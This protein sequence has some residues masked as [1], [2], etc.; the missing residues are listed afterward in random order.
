MATKEA[1]ADSKD[2][3][4]TGLWTI[5][6]PHIEEGWDVESLTMKIYVETTEKGSQ[7][8]AE[9]DFGVLTGAFR[10]ERQKEKTHSDD[11]ASNKSSDTYSEKENDKDED[12][13]EENDNDA[14]DE[15]RR[16]PTPEAFYFNSITQPS[17]KHPTWNYRYRGEETGEGVIE[18]GSDSELYSI[19]FCGPKG[20]TLTGTIGGGAFG[21]CTFTGVKVDG[22]GAEYLNIR[23]EWANGNAS[24]Y[25]NT[26]VGQWH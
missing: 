1:I 22:A 11:E 16:S 9:F 23:E 26:R 18:V 21:D 17:T 15:D 8:F 10:F 2:W 25:E 19:T 5:S 12:K 13:D 14:E 7:M 24:A 20:Q 3:D 4:V 6:C